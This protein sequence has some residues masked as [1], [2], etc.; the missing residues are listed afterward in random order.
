MW[1]NYGSIFSIRYGFSILGI[2]IIMLKH[3]IS[4]LRIYTHT[5]DIRDSILRVYTYLHSD[6]IYTHIRFSGAR[7]PAHA[8]STAIIIINRVKSNV[9]LSLKTSF[10]SARARLFISPLSVVM[11]SDCN[12]QRPGERTHTDIVRAPARI[13]SKPNSYTG[14]PSFLHRYVKIL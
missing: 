1:I 3:R 8:K 10:D 12:L 11:S 2:D 5:S 9:I 14:R 7:A 4:L 6:I 13:A